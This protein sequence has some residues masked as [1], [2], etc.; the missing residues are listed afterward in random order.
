[1]QL[2]SY[3][4]SKARNYCILQCNMLLNEKRI[5][6]IRINYSAIISLKR[7]LPRVYFH[8]L[9]AYIDIINSSHFCNQFHRK[10][11]IIKSPVMGKGISCETW[12]RISVTP[13]PELL[14]KS[15]P[16]GAKDLA[17]YA[18]ACATTT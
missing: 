1:M 16:G 7:N 4:V 11:I 5:F 13:G 15:E 17:H 14:L 18:R 2:V 10:T 8:L 12:R 6:Y 9:I 3:I